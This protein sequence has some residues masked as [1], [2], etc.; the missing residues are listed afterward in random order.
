MVEPCAERRLARRLLG[1]ALGGL[2]GCAGSPPAFPDAAQAG[3]SGGAADASDGVDPS[4]HEGEDGT[5]AASA[6]SGTLASESTA[7]ADTSESDSGSSSG[8]DGSSSDGIAV[9]SSSEGGPSSPWYVGHYEGTWN[10]SCGFL[11]MSG[12]GTWSVD[13]DAQG[14]IDGTY[15]GDYE[16]SITGVVDR[17][18]NQTAI[19][20]G[21][22]L[23][24]CEW[25]GV[26]DMDGEMQGAF[27]CP[28][29]FQCHGQWQGSL[30]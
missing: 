8:G 20:E 22:D 13:I 19:A 21:P 6:S 15:A 12:N 25:Q 10:G 18:G 3:T 5:T 17:Q 27:S 16:G 24:Q 14:Q 26:L 1:W 11:P 4:S 2:V 29:Q 23:G 7:E 30:Q 9:G 28:L